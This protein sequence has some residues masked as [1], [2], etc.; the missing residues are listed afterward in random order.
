[1]GWQSPAAVYL[2]RPKNTRGEQFSHI[3]DDGRIR[4]K[5]VFVR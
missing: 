1:L 5:L 2:T 4:Q 3:P